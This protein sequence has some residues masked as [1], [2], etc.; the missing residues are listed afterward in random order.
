MI[1]IL[2]SHLFAAVS[3]VLTLLCI[4]TPLKKKTAFR[5][6]PFLQKLFSYHSVYGILL[7]VTAGIHGVLA[8]KSSAAASGALVW[9]FLVFLGVLALLGKAI[10]RTVWKKAHISLSILVCVLMFA[11]V[12]LAVIA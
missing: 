2:F 5:S 8:G 11:H 3:I 12:V 10:P 7:I 6:S 9:I 4:L 1:S